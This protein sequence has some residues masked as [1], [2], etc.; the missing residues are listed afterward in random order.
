MVAGVGRREQD[1]VPAR[2]QTHGA[3]YEEQWHTRRADRS[4][5]APMTYMMLRVARPH[6]WRVVHGVV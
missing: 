4:R 1:D 3:A 5:C 2:A 6:E